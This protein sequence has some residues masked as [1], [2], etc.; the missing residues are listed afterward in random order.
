MNRLQTQSGDDTVERKNRA[1]IRNKECHF[2]MKSK[3]REL[4]R[5][6]ERGVQTFE[7]KE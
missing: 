6:S 7:R 5:F 3:G 4:F 2:E 1:T